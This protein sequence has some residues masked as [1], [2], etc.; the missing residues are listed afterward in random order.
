MLTIS[1]NEQALLVPSYIEIHT[2]H[3]MMLAPRPTEFLFF[4]IEVIIIIVVKKC[5]MY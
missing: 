3:T 2:Y 4:K 5:K 1:P